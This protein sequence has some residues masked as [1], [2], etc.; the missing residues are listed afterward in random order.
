[1]KKSNFQQIWIEV[2][3]KYRLSE[4]TIQMAK[5]LG[6]NPKKFG[7]I[8]NHKQEIWKEPLADF[9]NSPYAKMENLVK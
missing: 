9:I 1:M 4:T 3:R 7:S 2:K 5:K 6:L 8:A